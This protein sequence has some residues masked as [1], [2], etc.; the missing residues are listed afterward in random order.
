[1]VCRKNLDS[2]TVA[3]HDEEFYC[4]SRYGKKYGPKDYGYSQSA[5]MHHMDQS[6]R[7]GI[8]PETV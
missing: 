8:K 5:G 7:L 3:I 6:L 2:T 1:M 4:I